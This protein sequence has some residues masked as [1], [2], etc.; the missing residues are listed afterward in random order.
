MKRRERL[1]A[2]GIGRTPLRQARRYHRGSNLLL[3]LEK[4][5]P[6]GSVK[7]RTACYLLGDL[8]ARGLLKQGN[9]VV[10]SSS[11]NLAI[12]LARQTR[13]LGVRFYCVADP[14]VAPAKLRRLADEGA[15][16]E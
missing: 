13:G 3:K 10:E 9:W 2:Q 12:S 1:Y 7:D 5:N 14:T 6:D 15:V 4:A 16:V 8:E 11:G